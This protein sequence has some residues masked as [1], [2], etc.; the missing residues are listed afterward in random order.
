M[1]NK[2]ILILFTICIS[3]FTISCTKKELSSVDFQI[4]FT[5]FI[6]EDANGVFLCSY[7]PGDV[8]MWQ[9][10]NPTAGENSYV[11]LQRNTETKKVDECPEK[12]MRVG[13]DN[14]SELNMFLSLISVIYDELS[15]AEKQLCER[16]NL[17]VRM[18]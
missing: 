3:I 15:D 2:K 14:D 9:W 11:Y 16:E 4:E 5:T 1:V 6:Y 13:F 18:K 17:Y 10:A 7:D 12:D 8:K